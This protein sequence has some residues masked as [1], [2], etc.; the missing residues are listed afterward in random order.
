[1]IGLKRAAL[2]LARVHTQFDV[3]LFSKHSKHQE[4]LLELFGIPQVDHRRRRVICRMIGD[5][6]VAV[7]YVTNSKR[8]LRFITGEELGRSLYHTTV[9]LHMNDLYGENREWQCN[10]QIVYN[11]MHL[12]V[13]DLDDVIDHIA[14]VANVDCTLL[15]QRRLSCKFT[16]T[17][18]TIY[19]DD[20]PAI[21]ITLPE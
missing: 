3:G 20:E 11:L 19:A 16:E 15:K 4:S 21:V 12:M 6:Y 8:Y 1:M 7:Y 18:C 5:H 9:K 14:D 2:C 10:D 17:H 13:H